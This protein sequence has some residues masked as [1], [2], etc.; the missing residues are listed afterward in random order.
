[1][2]GWITMLRQ[3]TSYFLFAAETSPVAGGV[4]LSRRS[5]ILDTAF[6]AWVYAVSSCSYSAA[7]AALISFAFASAS[8]SVW[9]GAADS[10]AGFRAS[11]NRA[12]MLGYSRRLTL[13]RN[14]L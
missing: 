9:S 5:H 13:S 10:P 4:G 11:L 3:V 6:M 7:R 8:L 2:Y 12:A 1:M 14:V